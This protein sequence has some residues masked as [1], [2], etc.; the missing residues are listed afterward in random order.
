MTSTKT[1]LFAR[2]LLL[3]AKDHTSWRHY[4]AATH[5]PHNR[6]LITYKRRGKNG[7]IPG[8]LK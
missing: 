8:S 3:A 7:I 2:M 5:Q 6:Q 4:D 1:K